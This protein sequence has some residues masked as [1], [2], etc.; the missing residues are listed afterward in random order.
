[1]KIEISKEKLDKLKAAIDVRKTRPADWSA[2]GEFEAALY[3]ILPQLIELAEIAPIKQS[4]KRSPVL[5]WLGVHY[6]GR[7]N[8]QFNLQQNFRRCELCGLA[9]TKKFSIDKP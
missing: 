6:F 1:M 5:C 8:P 4:F 9:Q 7:W 2:M 3:P